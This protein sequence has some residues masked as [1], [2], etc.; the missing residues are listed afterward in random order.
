MLLNVLTAAAA[1]SRVVLF[2]VAFTDRS[3]SGATS[4]NEQNC[5]LELSQA[6]YLPDMRM[7]EYVCFI[8]VICKVQLCLWRK[9][10]VVYCRWQ[11]N[12]FTRRRLDL[13]LLLAATKRP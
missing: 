3:S 7:I 4:K 13:C 2:A 11:Q 5:K 6:L 9:S 10:M 12:L 1:A 8:A